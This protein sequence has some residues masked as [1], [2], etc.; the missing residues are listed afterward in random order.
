MFGNF[1]WSSI[2]LMLFAWSTIVASLISQIWWFK[3]G[4]KGSGYRF[5]NVF[6]SDITAFTTVCRLLLSIEITI[7]LT[8][9]IAF[10]TNCIW[11]GMILLKYVIQWVKPVGNVHVFSWQK[12]LVWGVAQACLLALLLCRGEAA[13]VDTQARLH[14]CLSSP[15]FLH[16]LVFPQPYMLP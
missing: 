5:C 16:R 7:V 1:A 14:L 15:A 9:T 3:F 6:V 13:L 10:R 12:I 8:W 4:S 11:S 2:N